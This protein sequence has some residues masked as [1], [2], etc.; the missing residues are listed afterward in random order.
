VAGGP[1]TRYVPL[2]VVLVRLDTLAAPEWEAL[3]DVTFLLPTGSTEQHG[4]HLPAGTD[5]AIATAVCEVACAAAS[6]LILAPPIP[7]GVSEH[8]RRLPGG[9]VSAGPDAF[10][11]YV[12]AVVRSL[13][14]P[15]RRRAVVVVNGHGGNWASIAFALD[16][17][18]SAEGELPVGA[19]S[20]WDLVPEVVE[21]VDPAVP[22]GRPGHAGAVETSVMLARRPELVR[23]ERPAPPPAT[24]G[25]GLPRLQRWLDFSR[26]FETGVIGTPG[27]AD[28]GLGSRL[29]EEAAARLVVL[30][31]E[32]R[33]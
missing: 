2:D 18:G 9:A 5:T 16:Q 4:P 6:D 23:A 12:A 20:W 27:L 17:V 13:V 33:G 29:V 14:D 32:L 15:A 21:G 7:Y 30:A 3:E 11:A 25:P 28:A 8:H 10:G 24:A 31:R 1:P 26:H 22:R 19:C